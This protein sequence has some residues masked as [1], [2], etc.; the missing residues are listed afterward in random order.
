MTDIKLPSNGNVSVWWVPSSGFVNWQSPTAP[1]INAGVNLSDG[2][3]WNDFSIGVQASDQNTDPAISAKNKVSVRGASKFGGAL[4]FY[5]PKNF[6]DATNVYSA[7][8][9]LLKVPGTTGYIVI[10]IDGDVLTSGSATASQPAVAASAND[11]VHVMKLSTDGWADAITGTDAFRFTITFVSQGQ[12]NVY[13]VVRASASAPT[14]A[15]TAPLTG[16]VVGTAGGK[17]SLAGT[18]NTRKYTRGLTWTSSVPAK[19]TVSN[20][21][22]WTAVA[23]AAAGAVNITATHPETGTVSAAPFVLTIT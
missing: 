9:D 12:L 8:Y 6:H 14:V 15:I 11:L 5:Y 2:I 10:R 16:T 13:T 22:V 17:G 21:G 18:V 23:G 3:S 20:N 1:E 19:V 4:S 7:I